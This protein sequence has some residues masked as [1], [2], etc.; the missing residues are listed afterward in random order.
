[1]SD[2]LDELLSVEGQRWR[3]GLEPD[4]DLTALLGTPRR[5]RTV[6]VLLAV[7]SVI[8]VASIGVA[9][10]V[11]ETSSSKG[12][13]SGGNRDNHG[14]AASCV[15]PVLSVARNAA[16]PDPGHH[17]SLGSVA[18]GQRV[19]VFGRW[20]FADPCPDTA[21]TGQQLPAAVPSGA[22]P[23]SLTTADNRTRVLTT[24]HPDSDASFTATLTVP[25]DAP[26]GHATITDTHDNVID[27]VITSS[28]NAASD[29]LT[30]RERVLALAA[31]HQEA[32][33]DATGR[34][35]QQGSG[36]PSGIQTVTAMAG[37][38]TVTD[39]NTGHACESGTI[40]SVELIG[41]VDIVMTGHPS[42][43]GSSGSADAAVHGVDLIV[44]ANAGVTCLIS[45][46]TGT[47]QPSADA[48]V[49]YSR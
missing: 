15:A 37:E 6:P 32:N 19:T 29:G 1:M 7:A 25:S 16:L 30:A 35:G 45:V 33:Q 48:T 40:I 3:D 43:P 41:D 22:V 28:N 21:T 4:P 27:L 5:R 26:L 17:P 31:A 9:V 47:V 11:T 46:R 18:R 38:G 10:I 49:L 36:W 23:L 13:S 24:A 42:L 34:G 2:H 44:D 20:Y 39:S 8:A 12:G 14:N